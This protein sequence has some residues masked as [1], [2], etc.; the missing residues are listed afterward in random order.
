MGDDWMTARRIM[1]VDD[2]AKIRDHFSDLLKHEGFEVEAAENGEVAIKMID[3]EFYDVVLID[4]NM[5][6]VD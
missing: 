2:E 5:P 1:V 3:Q 6:K 4:L